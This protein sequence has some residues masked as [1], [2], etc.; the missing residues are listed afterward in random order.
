MTAPTSVGLIEIIVDGQRVWRSGSGQP[1]V[2]LHGVGMDL[3]MWDFVAERLQRQFLVLRYDMIGHGP[4]QQPDPPYSLSMYVE[5][6]SLVLAANG[7]AAAGIVGFSMGSLVAEAFA[8]AHPAKTKWLIALNGVFNRSDADRAAVLKRVADA[9]VQGPTAGLDV[10]IDR[11]FTP[12]FREQNPEIVE[13]VR[14]RIMADDKHAFAGAYRVFGTADA[15]LAPHIS[16]IECPTLSMTG[17]FDQRSTPEMA[18]AIAKLVRNGEYAILAG[19]RHLTPLEVP[20]QISG[21]LE[22]FLRSRSLL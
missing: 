22:R 11:W 10:A 16:E 21:H 7:I 3:S 12:Q 17:E 15:E 4:S 14:Q 20:D 1:V 2:L 18:K 13:S 5:Q 9:E 6:L 19:Q 8:L